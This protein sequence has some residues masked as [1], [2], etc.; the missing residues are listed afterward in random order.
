MIQPNQA[1]IIGGIAIN[2]QLLNEDE[3]IPNIPIVQIKAS[4]IP[5][6][7][8]VPE[9]IFRL[10]FV[11][12]YAYAAHIL[13]KNPNPQNDTVQ[14]VIQHDEIYANNHYWGTPNML[15]S[16]AINELTAR[17]E[18]SM[19]SGGDVDLSNGSLEMIFTYTLLDGNPRERN[20][21]F[22]QLV[23]AGKMILYTLDQ[24]LKI[25]LRPVNSK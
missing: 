11:R 8:D 20:E 18:E 16:D 21:D 1:Q 15:C 3:R 19:Q 9:V 25:S 4:L 17:W 23:G 14:I 12:S 5:G 6:Q 13:R 22:N 10:A 2:I 7:V 24:Y